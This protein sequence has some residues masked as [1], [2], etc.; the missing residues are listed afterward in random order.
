MEIERERNIKIGL[1]KIYGRSEVASTFDDFLKREGLLDCVT[2][3]A[4]E[5]RQRVIAYVRFPRKT[6]KR[7]KKEGLL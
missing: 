5:C 6:K 2:K 7:M 1:M 3:V 4:T